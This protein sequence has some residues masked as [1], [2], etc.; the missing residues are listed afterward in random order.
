MNRVMFNPRTLQLPGEARVLTML[1]NDKRVLY[2]G[3]MRY[4]GG[5]YG[6]IIG[7]PEWFETEDEAVSYLINYHNMKSLWP[8]RNRGYS[9]IFNWLDHFEIQ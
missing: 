3:V 5:R 8:W 4:V 1:V 2:L 7:G 6:T 9:T